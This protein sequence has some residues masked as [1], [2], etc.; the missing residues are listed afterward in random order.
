MKEEG[1]SMWAKRE[2]RHCNALSSSS[3]SIHLLLV[4]LIKGEGGGNET[5]KASFWVL[6][7]LG[8]VLFWVAGASGE[9]TFII[10]LIGEVS[11]N[12]VW[13]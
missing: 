13:Q 2:M 3:C 1:D 11:C 8:L 12:Y 5:Q 10:A 7:I 4:A 9:E 6:M